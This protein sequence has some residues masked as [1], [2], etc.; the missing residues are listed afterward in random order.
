MHQVSAHIMPKSVVKAALDAQG[1]YTGRAG[2]ALDHALAEWLQRA[3]FPASFQSVS[4]DQYALTAA[5]APAGELLEQMAAQ[6]GGTYGGAARI[7][8]SIGVPA[9]APGAYARPASLASLQARL[10]TLGPLS[11]PTTTTVLVAAGASLALGLGAGA[12]VMHL[13]MRR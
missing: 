1:R 11:A 12:L 10:G 7:W 3:G 13:M 6:T 5:A 8:P 4:I 9:P 2:E